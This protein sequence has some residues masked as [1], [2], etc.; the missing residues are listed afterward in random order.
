M[1]LTI[2]LVRALLVFGLI[3]ASYL[4][5]IG[6]VRAFATVQRDATT[7]TDRRVVPDWL[8]RRRRQVDL[9]NAVRLLRGILRLR[10]VY[11]KLGQVLSIMGGFLPVVYAKILEP[12]QDKVPP[13]PFTDVKATVHASLGRPIEEA[14]ARFDPEP[15]ASASLGQ[16]HAATLHDGRQVAVKVL[17]AGIRDVVR[18]DMKVI[19]LAVKAYKWFVPVQGLERV[20]S[21]LV[22]LLRR[23][24]DY[25]HEAGCMERMSAAFLGQKDMLFPAVVH[26]L[27]S[28]DVLTMTYME[29]VKITNF[30]ALE[31][32]GLSRRKV[33]TR[34]V[35]SFYQQMLVDRFF[36]ADPHPGNFLVQRDDA[37]GE[38]RIVVLDFGAVCEV[39]EDMVDGMIDILQGIFFKRSELVLGGFH[40]MGFV[41][42]DGNK[43]LLERTVMTYFE[44]LLA[45]DRSAGQLMRKSVREL[46]QLADPEVARMEL[47]ELMRSIEYPEGWFYVERASVLLF[48]LVGQIEPE[49]DSLTIG[50][51]YVMPLLAERQRRTA[52]RRAA[53]G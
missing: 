51:P 11:I 38:P 7:G 1:A 50:L 28:P 42:Q 44:K 41:A 5:Q 8:V 27:T 34:L 33:A 52:E 46:E 22:D 26:E 43:E 21:S 18:V 19:R 9:V 40:K 12:L 31:A 36:H 3:F 2:R 6:L 35:Q 4:V 49:L 45:L 30:E 20:H 16:V 37:T 14:Y 17:Y 48:W 23:E 29:G 24:T 53:V 47:R 13:H 25:L 32:M 15:I 10:G 39:G